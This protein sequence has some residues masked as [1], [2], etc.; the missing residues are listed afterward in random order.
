M[1]AMA[2]IGGISVATTADLSNALAE[3]QGKY[4]DHK[5]WT[6]GCITDFVAKMRGV[7]ERVDSCE[8]EHHTD[9]EGLKGDLKAL[10]S[11]TVTTAAFRQQN[12]LC[13]KQFDHEKEEAQAKLEQVRLGLEKE[14]T[15]S[16]GGLRSMAETA[17][18]NCIALTEKA[19]VSE[20]TLIPSLKADLEEMKQKRLSETQRLEAELE[21]LKDL[22]DQKIAQT[23]AALRFYVNSNTTKL[24]EEFAPMTLA[25]TLEEDVK[26]ITEDARAR[27]KSSDE[28]M[29]LLKAEVAKHR[30]DQDVRH[31]TVSHDLGQHTKDLKVHAINVQNL[32][33]SFVNELA[34]IGETVRHDKASM[35]HEV[36]EARAA[37]ARHAVTN[38]SAIQAV[39]SEIGALKQ[40]RELMVERLHVEQVVAIVRDMQTGHVPQVTS[41]LQDLEDKARKLSTNQSKDH[42]VL[43]ELQK[44]TC[45]IRGHFKM[46][47]AI[48]A[49]LDD[50]PAVPTVEQRVGTPE[51]TRLPPIGLTPRR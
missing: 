32:Q 42:D 8:R 12:T 37:A 48:A 24:K 6:E 19:R 10:R 9:I 18:A 1:L 26:K 4:E 15:Q 29:A 33:N 34:S 30:S 23:A 47:H 3:M 45:A 46:F 11:G 49:G 13:E 31:E 40:F 21:K 41:A 50:K 43:S 7:N 25:M 27:A 17:N 28:A 51:D 14:I 35:M 44:A 39:A 20:E 16:I 36:A 5:K 2:G 38:D 22:C